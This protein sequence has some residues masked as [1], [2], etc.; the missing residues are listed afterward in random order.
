MSRRARVLE[1]QWTEGTRHRISIKKGYATLRIAN[2]VRGF[3]DVRRAA[4]EILRQVQN[5]HIPMRGSIQSA[6]GVVT[7][8]LSSTFDKEFRKT[9]EIPVSELP[10][11]A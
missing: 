3:D 7:I 1:T 2:G 4:P 6:D 5:V 8:H 10:P 11:H 9:V